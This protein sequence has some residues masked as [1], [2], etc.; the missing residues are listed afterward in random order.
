[1]HSQTEIFQ[2]N[3]SLEVPT[4]YQENAIQHCFLGEVLFAK[5]NIWSFIKTF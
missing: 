2:F 4:K 5:G 1:M 3:I